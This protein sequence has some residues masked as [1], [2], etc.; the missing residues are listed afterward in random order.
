MSGNNGQLSFEILL[1]PSVPEADELRLS[2]QV[3][4]MYCLFV[5]A[6]KAGLPVPNTELAKIGLLYQSRLYELRRAL[7]PCGWCI[8]LVQ[9]TES[10]LNYYALVRLEQS[11]FYAEHK[12]K[13]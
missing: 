12:D 3:E 1:N 4:E 13:L 2:R 8:D 5:E 9:K 11:T 7:I 10:G 6:K